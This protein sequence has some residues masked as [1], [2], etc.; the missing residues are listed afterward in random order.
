MNDRNTEIISKADVFRAFADVMKAIANG[1]R[2]EL[3]ELMAQGEHSVEDLARLTGLAVTTTSA[4]LQSLKRAGLAVTRR[5]RTSIRYRLAGD[6]VAE[7]LALAKRVSLARNPRMKET[8]HAF[9]A[10]PK[11]SVSTVDPT[12]VTSDVL[13]IDVRPRDEFEAAHFPGAVS[14]PL[15][16]LEERCGEIDRDRAVVLYSR[17]Q[18]CRLAR[19]AASRLRAQGINASAMTDG[20]L[21]WRATKSISLD[22]STQTV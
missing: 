12:M 15:D 13:V 9:M 6:D 10:E 7:L 8:L 3:L 18:L 2:L 17:G 5:E 1:C 22:S 16:E 20:V 14:I 4:H 21:E 11:T 19:E